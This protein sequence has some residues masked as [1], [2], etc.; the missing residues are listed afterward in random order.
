MA[1]KARV[2]AAILSV[3]TENERHAWTLDELHE[4]LVRRGLDSDFSSVFR[5]AEKLVAGGMIRKILLDDGRARLEP[6]AAHH[7]HLH[8]THC[9]TLVPVPCLVGNREI[10]ALERKTG[11]AITD[12]YL[13]LNGICGTCRTTVDAGGTDPCSAG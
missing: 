11:A 8:C 1:R 9:N 12:H 4:D 13:V 2:S 3:L 7:D 10:A 6:V 5:A